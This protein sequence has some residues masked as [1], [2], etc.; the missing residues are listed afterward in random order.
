MQEDGEIYTQLPDF[1]D[2]LGL[3][4]PNGEELATVP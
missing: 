4:L 2:P 3:D 1:E